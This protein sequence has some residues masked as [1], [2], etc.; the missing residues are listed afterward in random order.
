[1]FLL[2]ARDGAARLGELVLPHGRV[3]TPVFMPVGTLAS[4][5]ALSPLQ[6]REAGARIILGNT[7]HLALRPGGRVVQQLGGLASFNGW[8]GPTLTDSGGFQVFSLRERRKLDEDGVTF[9]DP[10][11]GDTLR[12]TPESSIAT[13]QQLGADIIMAFDECTPYPAS[14]EQTESSMRL[15]MRWAARCRKAHEDGAQHLFGIIQGGVYPQLRRESL[16]A[17]LDIGFAGYAIGGLAVGEPKEEMLAMVKQLGDEMPQDRPRYLMGVGTPLDL[18]EGVA[19]GVDM[20]DCVMPTRNARNGSL[21][22]GSGLVK[23]RNAAYATSEKPLD[24]ACDCYT[25]NNFSLA[26]LHHLEK[27]RELLYHQL[28]SLHN[29]RVYL[30]LLER[31]RAAIAKGVF[32]AFYTAFKTSPL[33]KV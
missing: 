27:N 15:S 14:Y 28:A 21:F 11:N 3:E 16:K 8:R 5:K 20:F 1:V 25:C 12:M 29:L 23:I 17:L 13:Q 30:S 10:H 32:A 7:F 24:D 33:A 6:L 4:V 31:I 9:S 18:V 19:R 22:T 2:K 26:Y